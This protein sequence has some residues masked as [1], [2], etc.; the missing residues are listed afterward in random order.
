MLRV[1]GR[2][3]IS[4]TSEG[5][6]GTDRL[7]L[8]EIVAAQLNFLAEKKAGCAFAAIAA[9]NPEQYGW[10]H[11]L[12]SPRPEFIDAEITEA[13][14]ERNITTL[15]L[16]FPEVDSR[17]K[18]LELVDT[19][20]RCACVFLEQDSLYQGSRCLGF[21]VRLGRLTSWVTGFGNFPFFPVTRQA[22][23][24]EIV[25]RVKPRPD[26]NRMMKKAPDDVVHLA[27]LHML[28]I[29]DTVFKKLWQLSLERTAR[30]LGHKPD[31]R[32]AAK[33]TFTLPPS[34]GVSA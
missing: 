7:G 22:P 5:T 25:F 33:T 14:A 29:P 9:N 4:D 32:S 17:G 6:R 10:Y 13:I 27:D 16:I 21:R 18:L 19:L 3:I 26:Y 2:A 20:Q 8:V 34:E 24:T 30:L 31:L 11:R 28:G 1:A 12:L 15:S 23:F